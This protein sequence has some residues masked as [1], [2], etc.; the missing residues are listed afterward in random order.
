MTD[1]QK[2]DFKKVVLGKLDEIH[3]RKL[4]KIE[5]TYVLLVELSSEIQKDIR[6][7]L[8]VLYFDKEIRV[9]EALNDK[10]IIRKSWEK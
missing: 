10:Y 7:I 3:N 6:S 2:E 8:N 1:E 5:P 9:G 4:G